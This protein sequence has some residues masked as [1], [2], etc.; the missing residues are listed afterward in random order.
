LLKGPITT[1]V[2]HPAKGKRGKPENGSARTSPVSIRVVL[3]TDNL[4]DI[5]DSAASP[6][7]HSDASLADNDC[8]VSQR[9]SSSPAHHVRSSSP[10]PRSSSSSSIQGSSGRVRKAASELEVIR[11]VK[12]VKVNPGTGSRGRV[13]TRDFEDLG[14]SILKRA[15]GHFES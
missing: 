2:V 13:T 4:M 8:N 11:A 3:H 14:R 10:L 15:F 9:P 6:R 12:K 7:R 1:V 5:D